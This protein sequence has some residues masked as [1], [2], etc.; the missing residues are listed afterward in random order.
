[1]RIVSKRNSFDNFWISKKLPPR[2]FLVSKVRGVFQTFYKTLFQ[3]LAVESVAGTKM[4][5][6][7]SMEA[8]FHPTPGDDLTVGKKVQETEEP[9]HQVEESNGTNGGDEGPE[10]VAA[11]P[12]TE[13]EEAKV[14]D[15]SGNLE[16]Y[17]DAPVLRHPKYINSQCY[18][19]IREKDKI[20]LVALIHGWLK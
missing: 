15:E 20:K 7:P 8:E 14:E 11:A 5:S 12:Y 3:P 6:D 2:N 18:S 19:K 10:E 17:S 13:P 4:E 16:L 9:V 1:M